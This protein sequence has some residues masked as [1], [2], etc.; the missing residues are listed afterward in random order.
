MAGGL[1]P[2]VGG[3]GARVAVGGSAPFDGGSF[4]KRGRREPTRE[5]GERRG[6]QLRPREEVVGPRAGTMVMIIM[7]TLII[8]E[9]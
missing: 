1:S 4:E 2:R 6:D 3:A 8:P 7:M 5:G 9:K